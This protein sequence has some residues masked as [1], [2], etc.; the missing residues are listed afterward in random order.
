M[1]AE[2]QEQDLSANDSVT[3]YPSMDLIRQ[4]KGAVGTMKM[5]PEVAVRALDLARDPE[6]TINEFAGVIQQDVSLASGVLAMANSVL[7]S[8][9]QPTASLEK[10]NA[11][12]GFRQCRNLI[13]A[14]SLASV[15]KKMPLEEQWVRDVLWQH[16]VT[17]ASIAL[18]LN[19]K[20]KLQFDGEEF[21][22]GLLHDFGRTL[23]AVAFPKEFA[24]FD[25][26]D[27]NE[28]EDNLAN[29][30]AAIGSDHCSIGAWFAA[31][32]GLPD[33][34]QEIVRF[35]HTPERSHRHSKLV[36]LTAVAD[37]MANH[38]QRHG[39]AEVYDPASNPFIESLEK[40]GVNQVREKFDPIAAELLNQ[41]A[42]DAQELLA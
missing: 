12:V 37:H 41:A 6:V 7:Y 15:M 2:L 40:A 42:A 25:P 22:G 29:E 39:E 1:S 38:F 9:G 10:G 31:E 26:L 8:P 20:L 23:M 18:H 27:F 36:A 17:T 21:T 30:E 14:S 13:V 24:A 32:Q 16:S 34:L 3:W 11:R 19:R 35:H 33:V 4:I 5:L 28:T